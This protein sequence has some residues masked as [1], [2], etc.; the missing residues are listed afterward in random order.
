VFY[1]LGQLSLPEAKAYVK[2]RLSCVGGDQELFTPEAVETI[3]RGAKGVPRVMNTICDLALVYGFSSG[4]EKIDAAV[5]TEV[6]ADRRRMGIRV[7]PEPDISNVTGNEPLSNDG[8]LG[9]ADR[10]GE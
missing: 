8:S 9:Y 6:L 1:H 4:V 3:W 5:A 2:H 7:A 10:S